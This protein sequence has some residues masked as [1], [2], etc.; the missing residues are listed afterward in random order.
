ML[1][2]EGR[3]MEPRPG[4]PQDIQAPRS[5]SYT[6]SLT[7]RACLQAL[8]LAAWIEALVLAH[9]AADPHGAG[10]WTW[11]LA[12]CVLFSLGAYLVIGVLAQIA[13][14]RGTRGGA[15]GKQERL[16]PED[17]LGPAQVVFDTLAYEATAGAVLFHFGA[18][19][20]MWIFA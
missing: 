5:T 6:V 19:L 13:R 18:P 7:A 3:Y 15:S 4:V 9:R 2:S 20:W 1:R 16:E 12:R 14:R 10:S 17:S 8:Q 11:F